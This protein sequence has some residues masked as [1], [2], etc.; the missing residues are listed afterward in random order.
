LEALRV[1]EP[2]TT[3][4][5]KQ[6]EQARASRRLVSWGYS[7]RRLKSCLLDTDSACVPSRYLDTEKNKSAREIA[8]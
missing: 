5:D 7:D 4:R 6:G 3:K 2:R 8:D 1:G